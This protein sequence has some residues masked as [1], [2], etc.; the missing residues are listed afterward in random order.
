M[1][2]IAFLLSV[3]ILISCTNK[4]KPVVAPVD[5]IANGNK[6]VFL[7]PYYTDYL[8]AI[9]ADYENRGKY[10]TEKVHNPI[11]DSYF[12]K[13]DYSDLIEYEFS[14]IEDT[15]NLAGNIAAI[16]ANKAK[17]EQAISTALTNCNKYLKNDS[18][19]IYIEPA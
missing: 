17:I 10:F 3:V 11:I 9:K 6:V 2:K 18:I 14:G 4:P 13:C 12:K 1:K 5:A 16:E 19:T 15:S 8:T 7:T